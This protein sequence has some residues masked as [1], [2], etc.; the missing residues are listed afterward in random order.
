MED[1][2][3]I[4]SPSILA[5]FIFFSVVIAPLAEEIFFRG[6]L[7][8]AIRRSGF[9]QLAL[10]ASA[11]LFAA[12]HQNL[13]V[14]IPLLVLGLALALLYEKCDNLLASISAHS[15]FNAL[16]IVY[17]FALDRFQPGQP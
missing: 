13:A 15:L 11:T 2:A 1:L 3:G 16:N 4:H 10:W 5:Y 9:R 17:F 6:I 7:Y 14:F 12:S 8:A